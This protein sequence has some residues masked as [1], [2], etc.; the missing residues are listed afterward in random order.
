MCRPQGETLQEVKGSKRGIRSIRCYCH[1]L[2][3]VPV[4]PDWFFHTMNSLFLYEFCSVGQIFSFVPL[5]PGVLGC[6]R[7]GFSEPHENLAAMPVHLEYGYGSHK[8][9]LQKQNKHRKSNNK[10]KQKQNQPRFSHFIL[11]QATTALRALKK[12]KD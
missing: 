5:W 1:S 7:P 10:T 9:S 8:T 12:Q 3:L 6:W 4:N 11:H 2:S